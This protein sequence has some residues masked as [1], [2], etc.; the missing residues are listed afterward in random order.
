MKAVLIMA[1]L[2]M[3]AATSSRGSGAARLLTPDP[4]EAWLDSTIGSAA[5]LSVDLGSVQTIDTAFIGNTNAAT[6]AA[7]TVRSGINASTEYN[8]PTAGILPAPY[9]IA[10]RPRHG[11]AQ[12]AVPVQARYV[13]FIITQ[14]AGGQP[15]YVGNLALGLGFVPT[16]GSEY[17]GGR[18][19][20]DTGARE[21]LLGG[22]FGVARGT[23]KANYAWTMGDLT[24]DEVQTLYALI[25]DRGET[26]PLVVIESP[27]NTAGLGE[28]SHWCVADKLE[29]YERFA[30]GATRWAFSIE[31]WT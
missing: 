16:W 24:D 13:D 7:M 19:V 15:M 9:R 29:P 25:Y 17:G 14:P 30:P 1:P 26:A 27:D 10:S 18:G 31:E 6:G 23:R 11:L 20:V 5:T 4:K 28:R 8:W 3:A 22:G 2:P 21:R 12:L